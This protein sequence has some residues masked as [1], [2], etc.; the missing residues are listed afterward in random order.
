MSD[1]AMNTKPI[2]P[3]KAILAKK[4]V[5]LFDPE[6]PSD[7]VAHLNYTLVLDVGDL[8]GSDE[9][10][11]SRDWLDCYQEKDTTRRSLDELHEAA[12]RVAGYDAPDTADAVSVKHGTRHEHAQ[13]V[14]L[15]ESDPAGAAQQ[16]LEALVDRSTDHA[17]LRRLVIAAE[18][19]EFSE[20][21]D[22]KLIPALMRFIE[23]FRDSNDWEDHIAVCAAIRTY[24]GA[25]RGE[26]ID[27]VSILLDPEHRTSATLDV[28][29]ETLKMIRRKLTVNP[30]SATDSHPALSG[31][32][33]RLAGAYLDPYVFPHGKHA[34]VAMNAVQALGGLASRRIADVI[35]QVNRLCP[36]WFRRQLRRRLGEQHAEWTTRS[37][38]PANEHPPIR[39][40]EEALG[41]LHAE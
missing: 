25:V 34:A 9:R 6:I 30:P 38:I 17:R 13:Y 12:H 24:V 33:E 37:P 1:S 23:S 29:L 8:G 31:H 32:V 35:D 11:A 39:L 18:A 3:R 16:V 40:I 21:Q 27:T 28:V 4:R 26:E 36:R 5:R 2:A 7:T 41:R 22:R 14:D 15:L 10:T 19:I 20:E